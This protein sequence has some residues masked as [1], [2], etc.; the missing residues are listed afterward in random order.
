MAEP[1]GFIA[2]FHIASIDYNSNATESPVWQAYQN[3][4]AWACKEAT[5]SSLEKCRP[6]CWS[7]GMPFSLRFRLWVLTMCFCCWSFGWEKIV[8]QGPVRD[9]LR[10]R[11]PKQ[12]VALRL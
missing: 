7:D 10:E 9:W 4:C 6:G 3:A 5:G 11:Y 12:G 1:N 2:T 8:V